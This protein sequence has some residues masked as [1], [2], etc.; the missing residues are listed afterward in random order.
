M[1]IFTIKKM[2]L[3]RAQTW[4]VPS[5]EIPYLR[6]GEVDSRAL[7]FNTAF[8]Y[9]QSGTKVERVIVWLHGSGNRF[10]DM[11]TVAARHYMSQM[12]ARKKYCGSVAVI[13]PYCL[14]DLLW[15]NTNRP[16]W[17]V[18]DYVI[19]DLIPHIREHLRVKEDAR[20]EIHGYSMGGYGAL[21]IGM[22]MH[23]LFNRI[24]AVGAG[25]LGETFEEH[26]DQ[27][28]GEKSLVYRRV[29]DSN[30]EVLRRASPLSVCKEFLEEIKR[31]E[32]EVVLVVGKEDKALENSIRLQSRMKRL[33]ITIELKVFDGIG[34]RL[35]EYLDQLKDELV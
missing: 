25:P 28:S 22:K 4:K 11:V 15:L 33:G 2:S 14:P 31:G 10:S 23:R 1:A 30:D 34:H 32:Q 12:I 21:R 13:F 26:A 5:I 16:E 19:R 6:M 35:D 3:D 9:M 24:L 8:Y 29:F 27:S 20:W 17:R 7:G 18:E